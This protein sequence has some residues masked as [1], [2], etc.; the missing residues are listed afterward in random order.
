MA[1]R[2]EHAGANVRQLTLTD[3]EF[4]NF[5]RFI[6]EAAGITL[7][8]AKKALVCGRLAKRVHA[9]QLDGYA[10]YFELLRSRRDTAEV[11]IAVDLLTTNET[12]FFREPKHFELLRRLALAHPGG[13]PFRIWSAACS[14]GEEPYSMAMVLSD[15]M[16]DRPFEVLGTDISTRML[17]R[18]RTGHYP[19]Q[20]ARL[21][22]PPYLKRFC[23]R[24]QGEQEGTMLVDRIVRNKVR[25]AQA[26]LNAALPDVGLFDTIFLRNVM[27]YFNG[28]TKRQVVAR[29][30]AQLRPGGYFC[31]G[32]SESLN[33]VTDAV[34]QLAPSVF[35]KPA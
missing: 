6:Y 15:C 20:R 7:S 25:F 30:L 3:Q 18:A 9:R 14:S 12:Y 31:I 8:S 16:Q 22:P 29:V 4:G 13:R 32:H 21:I 5:Q 11:Q 33:D 28:H 35:R 1:P 2:R 19:D 34:E 23:L 27:I 17:A 24:G 26:N 10:A